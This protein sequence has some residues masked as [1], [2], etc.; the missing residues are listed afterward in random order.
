MTNQLPLHPRLVV[1]DPDA[2]LAYYQKALDADIIE[3]FSDADDRVVH[4]AVSIFGAYVSLTQSVPQWGLH[5][6]L[7]LEGS[8]C[9]LHLTVS[10]PDAIA[11]R[12]VQHGG[13]VIIA[14][15]DR[16]YGKREGRIADPSGHLWILSTTIETLDNNEISQRLKYG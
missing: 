10:D 2:A 8:A 3:H 11:T 12:M 7:S 4:A 9:L 16:P 6:P 5:D 13:E 15:D 14:I 1:A